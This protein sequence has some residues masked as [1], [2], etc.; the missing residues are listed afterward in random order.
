MVTPAPQHRNQLDTWM[1]QPLLNHEKVVQDGL[2]ITLQLRV[3][4]M[5]SIMEKGA[6]R[7]EL[8]EIFTKR[9][10]SWKGVCMCVTEPACIPH[11]PP[12]PSLATQCNLR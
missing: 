1:A 2:S 4:R 3:P 8:I 7:R 9:G 10:I 6:E 12:P 5:M 11:R